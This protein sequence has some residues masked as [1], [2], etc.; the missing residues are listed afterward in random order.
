MWWSLIH[1]VH[2]FI[3]HTTY[4]KIRVF[5]AYLT[6]IKLEQVG[7]H[8]KAVGW[9]NTRDFLQSNYL[10]AWSKFMALLSPFFLDH[11]VSFFFPILVLNNLHYNCL[12]ITCHQN[13]HSQPLSYLHYYVTPS[14]IHDL[15][16]YTVKYKFPYYLFHYVINI[17]K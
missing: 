17:S 10:K 12:F 16:F 7:Y 13:S 3:S 11:K 9:G 15:C 5:F 14:N 2:F 4:F 1:K 6:L 8:R